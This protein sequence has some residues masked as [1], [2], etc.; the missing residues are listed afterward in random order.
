MLRRFIFFI[1]L[2]PC[3]PYVGSHAVVYISARHGIIQGGHVSD[4]GFLIWVW[5]INI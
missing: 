5:D 3:F 1:S 2:S 4:D